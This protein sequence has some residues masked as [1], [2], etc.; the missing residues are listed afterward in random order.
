MNIGLAFKNKKGFIGGL[1]SMLIAIFIFVGVYF[2][3]QKNSL[4]LPLT[5]LI[6]YHRYDI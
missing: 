1:I 3:Y 5:C 4:T 2:I 6:I